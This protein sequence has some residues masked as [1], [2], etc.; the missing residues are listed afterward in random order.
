MSSSHFGKPLEFDNS[1]SLHTLAPQLPEN[2][3]L[4]TRFTSTP[5]TLCTMNW[6]ASAF[7]L[8]TILWTGV[9]AQRQAP[10]S[11]QLPTVGEKVDQPFQT[12]LSGVKVAVIQLTP[13]LQAKADAGH[14]LE[15]THV[16]HLR[17]YLL[18]M[19]FDKVYVGSAELNTFYRE[20]Q[21]LCNAVFVEF[22]Y[23][24]V[25]NTFTETELVFETCLGGKYKFL[26][27]R[28][29]PIFSKEPFAFVYDYCKEL[30]TPP[31]IKYEVQNRLKLPS[32]RRSVN[33]VSLRSSLANSNPGGLEG[34]YEKMRL[35]NAPLVYRVAVV[36]E[37]GNYEMVYLD[38]D[39]NNEDWSVGELMGTLYP[40]GQK[41]IYKVV[42]YDMLKREN[43]DV[44]ASIDM[45]G[46]L[47][48]E[49]VSKGVKEKFIKLF[50][51]TE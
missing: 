34:I 12:F 23:K 14:D 4:A 48:L 17:R 11:G 6:K 32:T 9:A 49:F 1:R 25:K 46:Y 50:P 24:Q 38:G 31:Y 16:P 30:Y 21:N 18:G 36:K 22:N 15:T 42:W 20:T 19:G 10:P 29:F 8:L 13:A 2:E 43:R 37:S 39:F 5:H 3:L 28:E 40:T 27:P 44:L 41:G 26:S 7:L 33:E 51:T 45:Q 35:G 47:V